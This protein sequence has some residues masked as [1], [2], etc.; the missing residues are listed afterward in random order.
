MNIQ[1]LSTSLNQTFTSLKEDFSTQGTN[2]F[3]DFLN[4]LDTVNFSTIANVGDFSSQFTQDASYNSTSQINFSAISNLN[5]F[6]TEQY[7]QQNMGISSVSDNLNG[8][9]NIGVY[10]QQA[11]TADHLAIPTQSG[12]NINL[13]V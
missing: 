6:T 11:Y 5:D 12:L 7:L 3:S 9:T 4:Q 1:P 8:I 10:A 2:N 13:G